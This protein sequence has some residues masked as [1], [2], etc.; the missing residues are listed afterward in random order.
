[1][2]IAKSVLEKILYMSV[3]PSNP[4]KLGMRTLEFSSNSLITDNYS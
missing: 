4:R 2:K 1:M 3:S